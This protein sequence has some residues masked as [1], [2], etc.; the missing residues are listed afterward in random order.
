[1]V[2][3]LAVT[4]RCLHEKVASQLMVDWLVAMTK[5]LHKKVAN[6]GWFN[7]DQRNVNMK[8]QVT[9]DGFTAIATGSHDF[10]FHQQDLTHVFE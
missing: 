1:M 8:R 10:P 3:G 6:G 2:E 9:V 5:R 7:S 4:K